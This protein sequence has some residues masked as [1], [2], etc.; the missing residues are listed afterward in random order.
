MKKVHSTGN[1]LRSDGND[2]DCGAATD[3]PDLLLISGDPNQ[4]TCKRCR[5]AAGLAPMAVFGPEHPSKQLSRDKIW[6]TIVRITRCHEGLVE[7][8]MPAWDRYRKILRLRTFFPAEIQEILEPGLRLHVYCNINERYDAKLKFSQWE[9]DG[10]TT[11]QQAQDI[12]AMQL[13]LDKRTEAWRK[14]LV[15]A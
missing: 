12:Q 11:A 5:R 10:R 7:F 6:R 13:E 14:S 8:Q 3:R 2:T 15:D 9:W 1:V 4:I